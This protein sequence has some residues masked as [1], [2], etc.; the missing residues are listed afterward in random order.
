M[1]IIGIGGHPRRYYDSTLYDYLR[2][3]AAA[4]PVH[5]A[6]APSCWACRS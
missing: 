2:A 6:S 5:D 4:E 3:L 1:H